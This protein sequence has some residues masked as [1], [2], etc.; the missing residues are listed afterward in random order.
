M[1]VDLPEGTHQYRFLVDGIWKTISSE[2]EYMKFKNV[3]HE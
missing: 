3:F 2:V 1:I